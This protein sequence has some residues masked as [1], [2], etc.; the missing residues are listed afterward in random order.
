MIRVRSD[1]PTYHISIATQMT[2][3][4]G[5]GRSRSYNKKA[6]L[7]AASQPQRRTLVQREALRGLTALLTTRHPKRD[8][9]SDFEGRAGLRRRGR[10]EQNQS[11]AR[12]DLYQSEDL[13]DRK[14]EQKDPSGG[15]IFLPF[16]SECSR[17]CGT[18]IEPPHTHA[19]KKFTRG[20]PSHDFCRSPEDQ[21]LRNDGLTRSGGTCQEPGLRS[22]II[23]AWKQRAGCTIYVSVC[24]RTPQA[25]S[26]GEL[27]PLLIRRMPLLGT[28]DARSFELLL[29]AENG[30]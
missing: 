23:R 15:T 25:L 28:K 4:W 6:P 11:N 12:P 30:E 10:G 1:A 27:E 29:Q 16:H 22:C 7:S 18:R 5:W 24:K 3:N 26:E 19:R 9:G 2:T 17:A 14:S 21:R 13:G 20:P 8:V